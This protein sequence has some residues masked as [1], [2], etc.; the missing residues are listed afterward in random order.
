VQ[1]GFGP[2]TCLFLSFA[3]PSDRAVKDG[4]LFH[5][6]LSHQGCDQM[7]R[8]PAPAPRDQ[9]STACSD[10][11][12]QHM[13]SCATSRTCSDGCGKLQR[14][15]RGD[16]QYKA[17]ILRPL[18][19]QT[20]PCAPRQIGRA[21]SRRRDWL[22]TDSRC[23]PLSLPPFLPISSPCLFLSSSP[24][25]HAHFPANIPH[26]EHTQWSDAHHKCTARQPSC[27]QLML[28]TAFLSTASLR[29][30]RP[31][32]VVRPRRTLTT[33]AAG[34]GKMV[35][36]TWSELPRCHNARIHNVAPAVRNGCSH[37]LQSARYSAASC[38]WRRVGGE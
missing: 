15:S 38:R 11:G 27:S 17:A 19:L 9:R 18:H 29:F 34:T 6:Y 2:L 37:S 24:G 12:R 14:L 25:A 22:R 26:N 31:G 13:C 4:I 16:R 1:S 36:A 5:I 28:R 23:L 3:Q 7:W 10:G 8:C 35:K 30:V 21:M 20:D 32:R 33:A